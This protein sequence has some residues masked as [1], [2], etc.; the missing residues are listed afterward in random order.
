M[1]TQS[2]KHS[3]RREF[4]GLSTA[5]LA[6]GAMATNLSIARSAHA[7]GDETVK[8]ALVG[9]GGRGTGACKQSLC[10]KSG[11]VKLVAMADLFP[12]RLERSL[13]VLKTIDEI[14]DRIDVPDERKFY[15]FDA[16]QKAIDCVDMVLLT[17]PPAFRPAQYAAAVK[18]GKH[19]FMEKPCCVDA[20]GFRSLL[21]T[22]K[23]A[24]QKGLSVGVGMQ[25]RHQNNYIEGVKRIQDGVV[26]DI[27]YLRTY[28]NMHAGVDDKRRPDTISEMEYQIRRWGYFCWLSGDHLV[29]QA[30]HEIDIADWIMGGPP[31]KAN[32]MGGRQVRTG[33]GNGDIYDHHFI[34]YEYANGVRHFCQARQIGGTWMHISDNVRGA[35]GEYTLGTGPYG[36]GGTGYGADSVRA[37]RPK[38]YKGND[39]YQQEHNDLAAS[40]RGK[41]PK[42]FA[43]GYGATSSMTAVLGRMATYSGK[44]VTWDQAVKSELSLMPEKLALDATPPTTSNDDGYYPVAMPGITKAF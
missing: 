37:R 28:F 36:M 35:K 11:P 30:V 42:L 18:A 33:R 12:D 3:S 20:P 14:K 32:G 26:G 8:I 1:N 43:G 31:V 6:A 5:G 21:E 7:A 13:K 29:E 39:S 27:Q 9:C 44:V 24:Q 22:N 40:I 23:I 25:R 16:F 17:T 4:L 2:R 41:G 38:R 10:T 34:E 15:G 19:V